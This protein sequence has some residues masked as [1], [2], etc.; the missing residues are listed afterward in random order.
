VL[1]DDLVAHS[2]HL[3]VGSVVTL[4]DHQFV[5]CGIVLHGKGAR[6][7]LSRLPPA[8]YI[9]SAEGR[10]SMFYVRSDGNTE[11][12]RAEIV[13]LVPDSK[14]QSMA[15]YLTLISSTNLPGLNPFIRSFVGLGVAISFLVVLLTMHTLVLERTREIGIMKAL[16]FSKL[17]VCGLIAVEALVMAGLAV[18]VGLVL[19]GLIL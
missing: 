1:A 16:G 9:Q 10:V 7:F 4:V 14:V 11:A 3:K 13:K 17:E 15:E 5:V 18:A 12:A 19:T 6:V 2:K 8:Q